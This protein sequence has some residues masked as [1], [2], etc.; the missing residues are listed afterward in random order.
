MSDFSVGGLDPRFYLDKISNSKS[1]IQEKQA[2]DDFTEFL[3]NAIDSVNEIQ[4]NADDQM[5]R[6]MEGKVEDIHTAML[7]LQKADLSFQALMEVRNKI[8]EAYQEIM[9]MQV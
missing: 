5:A 3:K 1:E 9:R 2:G 6:V 7:E 8:L 4:K